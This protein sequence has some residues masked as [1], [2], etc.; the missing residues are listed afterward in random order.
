MF[1][2]LQTALINEV[3]PLRR[4]VIAK[5]HEHQAYVRKNS[6]SARQAAAVAAACPAVCT[7]HSTSMGAAQAEGGAAAAHAGHNARI[8]EQVM[9]LQRHSWHLAVRTSLYGAAFPAGAGAPHPGLV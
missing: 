8:V 6:V 3:D 9:L 5:C 1:E 4:R 7:T 2:C